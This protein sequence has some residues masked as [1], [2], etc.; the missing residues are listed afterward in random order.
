MAEFSG[1]VALIT[2]GSRGIG[3][4]ITL[5]LARRGADVV[6]NYFRNSAPA[7][8]TAREVESMGRRALIVKAH[9]GEPERVTEMFERVKEAY[10]G[11]DILVNNA[12]SGVQRPLR[13]LEPRHWDWAMEINTRGP[14][15]CAKAA[16]PLMEGRNGRIVNVSSLGSQRVMAD[17]ASVGVSKAA[18]EALTRYL[19]VELAPLG[20]R[21]NC[22][23]GGL[24][25][26]DALDHFAGR[27]D[28]IAAATRDTPAGRMVS[29]EDLA[30]AVAFLAGDGV[31]MIVGQTI[32]VD[33]GMGIVWRTPTL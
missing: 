33:G 31:E 32:V 27:E 17:Y 30:R 28:M 6:I 23:S 26:T 25:R 9:V 12:A 13:D 16:V 29:P 5:E 3:R 1:K 7:A 19:G 11:L 8:D 22:V 14:W 21:V 18:L 24:V 2:G 20:V 15:L 10:G 4:A